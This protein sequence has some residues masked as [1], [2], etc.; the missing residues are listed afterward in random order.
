VYGD[1]FRLRVKGMGIGEVL[2]APQSPWQNPF[3]ERLIGSI[4]RECLDHV[5]YF[6]HYQ[7][8]RPVLSPPAHA[9][10]L[11]RSSGSFWAAPRIFSPPGRPRGGADSGPRSSLQRF[12]PPDT[13]E[14][15][16]ASGQGFGEGQA[17]PRLATV[18]RGAPSSKVHGPIAIRL[19]SVAIFS[20]AWRSSQLTCKP[21]AGKH[22][23]ASASGIDS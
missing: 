13:T 2:T 16:Q 23:S 15:H 7:I 19:R 21:S 11:H 4:R 9:G 18:M 20:F 8:S 5:A 10:C 3:A 12:E 1:T 22:R 6:A 17:S 14:V